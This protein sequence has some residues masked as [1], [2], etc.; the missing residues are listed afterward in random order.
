MRMATNPSDIHLNEE[1]RTFLARVADKNGKP[2]REVFREAITTYERGTILH[3][4]DIEYQPSA[5]ACSLDAW[6][7][8]FADPTRPTADFMQERI[9]PPAQER[10]LF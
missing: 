10:E 2:W 6:E 5:Q 9:D 1:E 4:D 7:E 8:F 3:S